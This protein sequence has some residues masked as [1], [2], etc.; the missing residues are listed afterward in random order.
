M[1]DISSIAKKRLAMLKLYY[2]I[3]C[4]STTAKIFNVS[5]KTFYKWKKRYEKSY[6]RLFS[7]ENKPKTPIK[8]DRLTL[9]L[10]LNLRLNI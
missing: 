10:K 6:K 2:Q 3:K 4:V 9:T 1:G 5:R 8:K 7:L